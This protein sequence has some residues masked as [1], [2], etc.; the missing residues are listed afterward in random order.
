MFSTSLRKQ[1][2]S[3]LS[4]ARDST[5]A[6][7]ADWTAVPSFSGADREGLMLGDGVVIAGAWGDFCPAV[8]TMSGPREVGDIVV[9]KKVWKPDRHIKTLDPR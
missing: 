4:A 6:F 8:T 3:F 7:N 2:S 9:V 1:C 5:A